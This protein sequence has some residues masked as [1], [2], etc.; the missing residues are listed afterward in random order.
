MT[1]KGAEPAEKSKYLNHAHTAI[2]L[3][4]HYIELNYF[5][6]GHVADLKIYELFSKQY[7]NV[8]RT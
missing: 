3:V 1:R 7:D 6:L 5:L 2:L 8:S 4:K